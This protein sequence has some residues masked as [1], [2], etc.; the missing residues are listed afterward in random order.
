[1]SP[2]RSEFSIPAGVLD[3]GLEGVRGRAEEKTKNVRV[4]GEAGRQRWEPP[5][6]D[7]GRCLRR[8]QV[9]PSENRIETR[10]LIVWLPG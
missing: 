4:S 8:A 9:P 10:S 1:M 6:A 5:C 3:R 7:Q 2:G